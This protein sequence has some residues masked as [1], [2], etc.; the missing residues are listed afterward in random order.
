MK[1]NTG[2][3]CVHDAAHQGHHDVIRA[4]H[5]LGA[6]IR[7]ANSNGTTP[8]ATA[9]YYGQAHTIRVLY[10]LGASVA[11][12][13]SGGVTP[14]CCAASEGHC[15]AV[16]ALYS[17]GADVNCRS[18]SGD[19]PCHYA[20][21]K[22]PCEVIALLHQFGA[23]LSIVDKEKCRTPLHLAAGAGH[24]RC[25]QLLCELEV[26]VAA[27]DCNYHAAVH[28][29]ALHERDESFALLV[30][31]GCDI[32]W[33]MAKLPAD[34]SVKQGVSQFMAEHNFADSPD[35]NRI[36][37][38]ANCLFGRHSLT[39]T[40]GGGGCCVSAA[41]KSVGVAS[42]VAACSSIAPT[43]SRRICIG[44]ATVRSDQVRR[45]VA[46]IKRVCV[47]HIF[48]RHLQHQYHHLHHHPQ[49][50]GNSCSHAPLSP[51]PSPSLSLIPLTT[52]IVDV[53]CLLSN[54]SV[55]RDL[56]SMR[57]TSK[58]SYADVECGFQLQ[59][60]SGAGRCRHMGLEAA[61]VHAYLG[62][63]VSR[64]LPSRVIKEALAHLHVDRSDTKCL[65]V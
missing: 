55:L 24:T 18:S 48:V 58:A 64:H 5:E 21:F 29:A 27:V 33:S 15:S 20:A 45:L 47:D 52:C 22:G 26:D 16:D 50:N 35:R 46:L 61:V 60:G 53:T 28:L 65:I 38:L 3:T 17:L 10:E 32:E 44:K 41:E 4:L 57:Q 56:L 36:Y 49:S 43:D 51:S 1:D 2:C 14:I 31:F 62:G 37:V 63:E 12:C 11:C 39:S 34:N 13:D 7:A 59:H 23:D 6:D 54:K 42:L 8:M 25:V 40:G 9:A 30:S 19:S